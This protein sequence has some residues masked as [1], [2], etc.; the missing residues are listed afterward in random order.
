MEKAKS[1]PTIAPTSA[2]PSNAAGA[3]PNVAMPEKGTLV[4]KKNTAA[5]DPYA[6]PKPARSNVLSQGGRN[7]A[8]YG[9]RVGFQATVAP[10][11]GATQANGR[12]IAPAMNRSR[13]PFQEGMA[14]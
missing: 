6:Q 4:K 3:K 2:A 5:G 14:E 9:V 10:E 8:R 13:A 11:A 1:N 12:I 7:G